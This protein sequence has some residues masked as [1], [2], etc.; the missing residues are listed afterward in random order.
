MNDE[1]FALLV[2]RY[3]EGDLDATERRALTE[4]V[5]ADGARKEQFARQVRLGLELGAIFQDD[6]AEDARLRASLIVSEDADARDRRVMDSLEKKLR[7]GAWK[8]EVERERRRSTRSLSIV[9]E[10]PRKSPLPM[11]AAV[12]AAVVVAAVG[13][14]F[15][16][17]SGSE[18]EP[19]QAAGRK[20]RSASEAERRPVAAPTAPS[21]APDLER[22]REAAEAKRQER[23]RRLAKEQ[24]DMNRAAREEAK[25]PEN[26]AAAPALP[27][28]AT[29]HVAMARLVATT[30]TVYVLAQGKRV[31]RRP[32]RTS[33]RGRGSRPW[34]R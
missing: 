2:Q 1:A 6:D 34:A 22:Q 3:A 4:A 14:I 33:S 19:R 7:I 20:E 8:A 21:V 24:E 23:M 10:A 27:K 11:V 29:T 30:G 18:P 25:A 26:E 15:Y 28:R 17:A 32:A 13:L 16:L 9:R 31:P 5:M 12:A